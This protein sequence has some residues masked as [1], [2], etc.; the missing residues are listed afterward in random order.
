MS[1][2]VESSRE[3]PNNFLLRRHVNKVRWLV[4]TLVFLMLVL[5]PF[6]HLYRTYLESNT[7]DLL[8]SNE[9]IIF[10]SMGAI[11]SLSTT[12]NAIIDNFSGTTWTG[13]LFGYQLSDPLAVVTNAFAN[14]NMNGNKNS[15]WNWFFIATAVI[16]ITLTLL[17]G[18]FFCGWI[19][20]A[21]FIYE[22][23]DNLG[24]WLHKLGWPVGRYRLD[25]R[26]KYIVLVACLLIT[27]P[28]GAMLISSIYPPVVV[29]RELY[30]AIAMG[31]FGVGSLFFVTTMLFDLLVARRG[32]CRYLCPGGALYSLLGRYRFL[33]IK[34]DVS[35]C[36]DCGKCNTACQF[37]LDPM[38]DDFG[39]ECNN[40]SACVAICPTDT[41]KFTTAIKDIPFQGPGY[42][43]VAFA[44]HKLKHEHKHN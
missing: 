44:K 5:L 3:I 17:L 38:Q 23:N 10:N 9:K 32:F 41:L 21:T 40:C 19:C 7:Y 25:M 20:P 15:G 34:R 6:L 26:L 14:F 36:N 33:R 16:P 2:L 8:S 1:I 31:G 12:P 24:V 43:G 29:G 39:Q 4:L 22:L 11:T 35:N 18:R 37:G 28:M 27:I 30:F 42:L 13:T